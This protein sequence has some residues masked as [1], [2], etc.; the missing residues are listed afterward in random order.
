M[1]VE[2]SMPVTLR[3]LRPGDE[4]YAVGW[5]ADPEF[6]LANGWTPDLPPESIR[7]FWQT[8]IAVPSPQSLRLGI[9]SEGRLVGFVDLAALSAESGEFGIAIGESGLWGQGIGTQAGNLLLAHAFHTLKLQY[10]WAEV[11]EPNRR[12]HALMKKLG[13]AET[14]RRGT[15]E[16]Q[17]QLVPMVQYT[18]TQAQFA[19][20]RTS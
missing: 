6:C 13:F 16:Y 14:S 7:G 3:P 8:L 17:G 18:L 15:D 20:L 9:E 19:A 5:G 12:S 1:P 4:E 11:H 2:L 10:V